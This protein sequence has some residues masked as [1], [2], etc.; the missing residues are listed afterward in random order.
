MG[1]SIL[2]FKHLR[3]QRTLQEYD[4]NNQFWSEVGVSPGGPSPRWGAAGGIDI[5]VSFISD[6]VVPGPN[7]TFYLAGGYDGTTASPLSDVWRFNISGTL[8]SNLPNDSAGSWEHITTGSL[9]ARIDLASTM[10]SQQIVAAGGCSL[11][12]AASD[13]C[14]QQDSYVIDAR[15]GSEISP[16]PCPSPRQSPVLVANVNTFSSSFSSQVFLLLGTFDTNA[17]NDTDG[18]TKGEVVGT[19][20]LYTEVP[21]DSICHLIGRLGYQHRLVEQNYSCWRSWNVGSNTHISQSQRGVCRVLVLFGPG[22]RIP[23]NVFRHSRKIIFFE[24]PASSEDVL[25]CC[26]V[27]LWRP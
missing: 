11:A 14:P 25:I 12:S 9:P 21:V 3:Y 13:S 24:Y 19:P 10:I 15:D 7:N 2:V 16:G 1:A 18:L 23:N 4:F 17:W 6:P 8:S 27:D 20:S 5:R 22:R 26:H